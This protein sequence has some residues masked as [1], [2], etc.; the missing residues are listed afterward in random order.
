MSVP[1]ISQ[2][3]QASSSDEVFAVFVQAL[4][5]LGVPANKWRAGGVASTILRVVAITYAGFS[6]LM[7]AALSA[8]FL[9][10]ATGDW[11]TLLAYYLYGVT[12]TPASPASTSCTL[13]NTGGG[14][15]NYDPGQ[16]T[17]K[18]AATG[19][20][21]AT[22]YVNQDAIAL[23]AAGALPTTQKVV[24]VAQISGSAGNANPGDIS[25][26]VTSAN[27]VTVT[28]P[29]AAVGIDAQSDPNLRDECLNSLAARSVRNPRNAYKWAVTTA[30]N[31]VTNA[32]VA[33]NRVQVK[34]PGM[35][36]VGGIPLFPPATGAP[37]VVSV[38]CASPSGPATSDD[39]NGAAQNIE[40]NVRPE[41]V[42]VSV[43]SATEIDYVHTINVWAFAV[44]GLNASDL[45]TSAASKVATFFAGYQIGGVKTD[46]PTTPQGLYGTALATAMGTVN[47]SIFLVEDNDNPGAPPPDL[48][49]VDGQ[50]ATDRVTV[51]VRLVPAT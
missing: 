51:N 42:F 13:T 17:I 7:V 37:G 24:F 40:Q 2:L 41:G 28:N 11:L 19:Q 30:I 35:T 49:L 38:F 22:T 27:G 44:T 47:A 34:S 16:F 31:P 10:Y 33:I 21:P 39:L 14:I 12:R 6:A 1:S 3:L 32:P 25:V 18:Q 29:A 8:Q 20:N 5:N 46:S 23:G 45:Q 26:L 4:V 43:Q 15:Y 36:Y 48:P 50:V 9:P